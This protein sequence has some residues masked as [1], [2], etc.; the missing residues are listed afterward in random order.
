MKKISLLLVCLLT[1]TAHR[2]IRQVNN[3]YVA[4]FSGTV[5][6]LIQKGRWVHGG[7]NGLDWKDIQVAGGVAYGTQ[8]GVS[9]FYDDSV[10]ILAGTWANDQTVT[11]T[12][13]ISN[14]QSGNC[15]EEIEHWVR[16]RIGYHE[17]K[18]YEINYSTQPS[19]PYIGIVAWLGPRG[20]IGQ[21]TACCFLQLGSN[22][23]GVALVENDTIK[24][25]VVGNVITAFVNGVQKCQ[26]TDSSNL[27]PTGNPGQGHWLHN[28]NGNSCT[29]ALT[30]DYG[31]KTLT[32]TAQ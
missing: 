25:T 11:S 19:N 22:C 8:S 1:L 23:T 9:G 32:V 15:F 31:N 17:I 29:A 21:S 14:T 28:T 2:G 20:T 10:A 3:S 6:P 16:T 5:N 18:G 30:S 4:D 24:S 26:Q 7:L 27:Y 12:V 13:H